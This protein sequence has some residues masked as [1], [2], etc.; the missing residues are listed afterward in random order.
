MLN[1]L[2]IKNIALIDSAE[3]EFS[4]GLNVLSGETGSGK[5]VI[6]ESLNFAL[7]AKADKTLIRSGENECFVSAVFDVSGNSAVATV[8]DEFDFG[9]ENEL[10]ITRKYTIDGKSAIKINGNTATVSMLRKFTSLLVDV[11]GQSEHFFL[12]KSSNQLELLDKV[13]GESLAKQKEIVNNIYLNY[14]S[15][16]NE[17]N[18]LGGDESQKEIRLD[19]LNYQINEIETCAITEGEE[20]ELIIL[21]NKLLNQE[22]ILLALQSVKQAINNEGG[23]S[24]ILG[25]VEKVVSNISNLNEEY[26]EIYNRLSS[27][28]SE[29]MDISDT[30]DSLLDDIDF[31]GQNLDSVENRLS[32]IKKIKKNMVLIIK[33]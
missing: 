12:L 8:F 19:I 29:L 21:K 5:S 27:I 33:L 20:D 18:K 4:N 13:G 7:G 10:I 15:L 11:H 22:K 31:G 25:N 17:L 24:D 32:E 1:K 26:L 9:R 14:K 30:S 16:I 2:V 3:I 6:L 23:I 28:N